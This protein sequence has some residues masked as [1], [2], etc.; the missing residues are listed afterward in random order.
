MD[1][2]IYVARSDGKM[3]EYDHLAGLR[4]Q[5]NRSPRPLPQLHIARKPFDQ[6]TYDDF[7]LIG[8]DP[9]PA[10]HFKVAV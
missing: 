3:A 7:T 5:L 1:A 10:I 4:E 2:H 9:H 6:L 8:Y